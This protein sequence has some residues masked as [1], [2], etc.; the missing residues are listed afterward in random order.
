MVV[1]AV[2]LLGLMTLGLVLAGLPARV[3]RWATSVIHFGS[4]RSGASPLDQ[5]VFASGACVAYPPTLGENRKTV[6]LDA[7]HGGID[8]GAVGTTT[9]GRQVDESTVNLAIEVDTASLLRARGFRVV[10]SRTQDTTVAHLVQADTSGGVLSL[11]GAHDDVVA[12]DMCA[13]LA[14]AD[15]LIGI[16]MDAST[17]SQNAGSVTVYDAARPF[18]HSNARLAGLLQTSVLTAMNADGWQIPDDGAV[19]DAGYGSSV[20]DPSAGGLAAEAATYDHLLLIGPADAGFFSSP[21]AMP[22]A[23]IEP[24]YLTDPFEASIATNPGDQEVVAQ[25]IA[26]AVRQFLLTSPAS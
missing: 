17:S 7:G 24:L 15:A 22:G 14:G 6:F 3:H 26:S 18:A 23:V 19:P 21:S 25:G 1:L 10:V 5:G 9:S 12:R 20:G 4:A 11:E 8:P 13:N 2:L 16:Y